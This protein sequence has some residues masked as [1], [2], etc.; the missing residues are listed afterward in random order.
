MNEPFE[1]ISI[2]EVTS[3]FS[4]KL[5]RKNTYINNHFFFMKWKDANHVSTLISTEHHS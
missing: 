5:T 2:E 1:K 3:A 4:F